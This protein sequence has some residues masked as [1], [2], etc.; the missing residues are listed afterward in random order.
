MTFVWILIGIS[1]IQPAIYFFADLSGNISDPKSSWLRN[2]LLLAFL[3]FIILVG[4]PLSQLILYKLGVHMRGTAWQVVRISA[5]SS[6]G[7][8][9]QVA[10]WVYIRGKRS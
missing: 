3:A 5:Y 6:V 10:Q 4:F 1:I 8:I 2:T 9:M 7:V